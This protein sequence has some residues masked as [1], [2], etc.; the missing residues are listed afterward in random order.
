MSLTK[1]L[2]FDSLQ[3]P[4]FVLIFGSAGTVKLLNKTFTSLKEELS[5]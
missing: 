1:V 4:H 5:K 2:L 3:N